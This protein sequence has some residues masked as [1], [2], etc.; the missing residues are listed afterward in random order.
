MTYD[1]F[2][3]DFGSLHF[4][5]TGTEPAEKAMNQESLEMLELLF[6]SLEEKMTAARNPEALKKELEGSLF[7]CCF[8][9][10]M[11]VLRCTPDAARRTLRLDGFLVMEESLR[12]AWHLVR[13]KL[14]F[15]CAAGWNYTGMVRLSVSEI[16]R[17]TASLRAPQEYQ[18]KLIEISQKMLASEMPF[19]F[20]MTDFPVNLLPLEFNESSGGN[21]V[22][23][24]SANLITL[25]A[26]EV[27]KK[28]TEFSR[29]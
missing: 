13:W 11:A 18:K 8:P 17:M 21:T 24:N 15:V 29:N 19:S 27:Q 20:A 14:L 12:T 5:R 2:S 10:G 22:S 26:E 4:P 3:V 1:A 16:D 7:G 28:I 9:E 23:Q 6:Q 25:P